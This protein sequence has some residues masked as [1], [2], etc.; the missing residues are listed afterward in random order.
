MVTRS[1]AVRIQGQVQLVFAFDIGFQV[2]LVAAESLARESTRVSPVR[3]RRSAPAWFD[4]RPAPIRL[5]LRDAP[6]EAQGLVLSANPEVILYDFGAAQIAFT[7]ELGGDL[8]DLP[9]L[10]WRLYGDP[11]LADQARARVEQVLEMI[12]PAVTRPRLHEAVEDFWI[13]SIKSWEG[14]LD[15]AELTDEQWGLLART[16]ESERGPLARGQVQ[17]V[18]E[19][20]LSYS[21][22]DLALIDW[23]AAVLLDAE[24]EDVVA[25]LKHANVELLELRVLDD[26]LDAL[27]DHAD[28]TLARLV[29]KRMW[30]GFASDR[31]LARFASVQTDAVVL[32]EGV[33]NA[34]KLLGNQY[35][36]RLHRLASARLDLPAWTSS[37]ERKLGVA[38][39]LYQKMSDTVSTRRLEIL[40]WVII[41]LIFISMLLPFAPWYH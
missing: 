37:V 39:S 4:Y 38:E 2:D 22:T 3:S 11:S 17:R 7:A 14:V 13:F 29:R 23:N 21:P 1:N 34:I 36:A 35:L 25:V 30:P 41:V 20:C 10:S 9:E 5:E 12:R 8:A 6:M 27:L 18:R 31:M 28:E 26:E 16:V 15:P 24:P 32:F 40:E 19:G 33:N